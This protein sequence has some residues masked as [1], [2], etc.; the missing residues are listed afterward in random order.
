VT[1]LARGG[2]SLEDLW[3]FNDEAVVRAVVAS[4]VASTVFP[5]PPKT[6]SGMTTAQPNSSPRAASPAIRR[7]RMSASRPG[8]AEDG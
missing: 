4:V 5:P 7:L 8:G 3:A 2:G 1:I 6:T